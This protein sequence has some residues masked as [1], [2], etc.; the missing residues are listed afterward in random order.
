MG[1]VGSDLIQAYFVL[2]LCRL[3][4]HCDESLKD[5][6]TSDSH[7]CHATAPVVWKCFCK[8]V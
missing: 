8:P 1:G 3:F 4:H 7:S 2:P 6:F 5:C